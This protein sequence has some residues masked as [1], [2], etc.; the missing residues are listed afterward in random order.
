MTPGSTNND[1]EPHP[2]P[3]RWKRRGWL[4]RRSPLRRFGRWVIFAC[5]VLIALFCGGFLW[6]ANEVTSLKTPDGVKA[7]A[8]VVLTGGYQRIDQAVGLLRDG[9]G[10]RLLISGAHP[11]ATPNQIRKTTQVSTDLFSCCV[12]IG[13][14][15][16]DTIGNANEIIRWIHDHGYRSVVVVT[17]NYHMPRSLHEL[18]R[19]DVETDFIPYPVINS[20]LARK[21]WFADPDALRIMLGEYGKM[22]AAMLRDWAGMNQGSGLRTDGEDETPKAK[23]G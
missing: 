6:F 16:I 19:R 3:G 8:I 12:D 15:A 21:A 14:D 9:A 11:S 23:S 10:K 5:L 1:Q 22:A 13:Y 18:R 20:D 17:N 2:A 7:D 4:S